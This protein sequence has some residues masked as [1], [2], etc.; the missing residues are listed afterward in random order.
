MKRFVSIALSCSMFT[1]AQAALA[2]PCETQYR[3][4]LEVMAKQKGKTLQQATDEVGGERGL[5]EGYLFFTAKVKEK[6]LDALHRGLANAKTSQT[7]VA[8][9]ME[10]LISCMIDNYDKLEVAKPAPKGK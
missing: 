6:G 2:S 9:A 7:D 10:P 1:L 4:L 5:H 3:G 8:R